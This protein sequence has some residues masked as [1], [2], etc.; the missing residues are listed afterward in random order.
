MELT[1]FIKIFEDYG[2]LGGGII[3]TFFIM[4]IIIKSKPFITFLTKIFSFINTKIIKRTK[5][6]NANGINNSD[7]I[8]HEMFNYID[9]WL[10]SKIPIIT[11]HTEFRTVVLKRY[12]IIY[13]ES[14]KNNFTT[15]IENKKYEK[16]DSSQLNKTLKC[17]LNKIILDYEK[18]STKEGIPDIII[19]KMKIKN[20]A[21]IN[22][23]LG[24]IERISTS[25]FYHDEKNLSKIYSILNVQLSI[26]ESVISNSEIVFNELN[27]EL[28]GAKFLVDGKII[29]E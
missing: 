3:I 21:N 2:L 19:K 11:L 4:Y 17:L 14:Y 27:G 6:D 28:K 18:N 5:N 25:K 1:D 12:L 15:F 29:I 8:N 20:D 10:Y 13:L 9:F 22:L 23:M 16:M 26:L 7:I 24:L